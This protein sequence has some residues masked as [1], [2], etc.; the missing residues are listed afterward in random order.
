MTL[1]NDKAENQIYNYTLSEFNTVKVK[2]GKVLYNFRC[3]YN[4]VH[5][6]KKNKDKKIA[7]CMC[8]RNG[9]VFIHFVN[10][11][12]GRYTDN[13]LGE[14]SSIYNYYFIRWIK[15]E[16]M[17]DVDDIFTAFRYSLR[18]KLSWWVRLTSDFCA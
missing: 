14:W 6:A 1:N 7:M 12:K 4:A 5:F 9:E 8:E 3:Q 17:W 18:Q 13:T 10:Y 15:Q 2:S 16:D 11:H